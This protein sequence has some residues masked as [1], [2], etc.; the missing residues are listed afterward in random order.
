MVLVAWA[1]MSTAKLVNYSH[2]RYIPVTGGT[3]V[4]WNE[5]R[6]LRHSTNLTEYDR[7]VRETAETTKLFPQSHMRKILEADVNHMSTLLVTLGVHHRHAR[8]LDVIGRAL[9]V[10]AGTPD[11]EDLRQIR[12]TEN[13]LI[14][15]NNRQIV[16][17]THTQKQINALTLTVNEI[18]KAQKAIQID[19]SHLYETLL[20]R[21][22]MLT[23][24][25]ENLIMAIT[26]ATANIINPVIINDGDLEVILSKDSTGIS[27]TSILSVSKTKI[28]ANN[29]E[30]HFIITLPK[31]KLICK[32]VLIFPVAHAGVTLQI[33]ENVVA[34]CDG[35]IVP[36]V[37]C[38]GPSR[39][40]FCEESTSN[41]CAQELHAGKTAHCNT[42]PNHLA[43]VTLVDDG[44]LVLNDSPARVTIDDGP[45]NTITGTYLVTFDRFAY[46][47]GTR[48]TNINGIVKMIPGSASVPA[49]DVVEH[50]K[51]LSLPFLH[52]LS[53]DNLRRI[54][55]LQ[56]QVTIGP[57]I[58]LSS[59][60]M[61]CGVVS[62]VAWV[63]WRKKKK[64]QRES[65]QEVLRSLKMTEDAHV[66]GGE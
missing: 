21:N 43:V 35:M 31:P 58:T 4:V 39:M 59:C 54:D 2:S 6:N 25:I 50:Q 15:E 1:A 63:I 9:K 51:V 33:K 52:Q 42:Q 3:A 64:A 56:S 65:V 27:V 66:L 16:I 60:L 22:R 55:E 57:L 11:A 24:E 29:Q 40:S 7:L 10:I 26:L 14:R 44:I 34:D 46:V 47:N 38:E 5:T 45:E 8:S 32:K 17:N 37:S 41:T 13:E 30:I 36:I 62:V 61:L 28:L 53:E 18:L 48:F 23:L 20:A 19:T 49:L 12:L